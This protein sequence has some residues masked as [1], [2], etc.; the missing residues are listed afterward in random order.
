VKWCDAAGKTRISAGTLPDGTSGVD[1]F[2]ILPTQDLEPPKE[3]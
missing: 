2:V 3:P 1:G